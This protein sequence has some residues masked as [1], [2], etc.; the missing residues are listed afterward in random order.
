METSQSLYLQDVLTFANTLTIKFPMAAQMRNTFLSAAGYTVDPD[1]QTTWAY[2]MNL[3]GQYHASDT[4]MTVVSLD[5]LETIDFT[6]DNLLSHRATAAAYVFGSKYYNALVANFPTQEGLIRGIL[7]P[8]DIDTAIAADDYTILFYDSSHVET[9]EVYFIDELQTWVNSFIARY[10]MNFPSQVQLH[11]PAAFWAVLHAHLPGEII[12]IRNRY[13]RTQYT[14][15]YHI[16][17]YLGSHNYLNQY[18]DYCSLKQA[19]YLYRNIDYIEAHVGHSTTFVDLIAHIL[20]DR[21]I[22]LTA[23]VIQHDTSGIP[24]S[25]YSTGTVA[26]VPQNTLAES[27]SGISYITLE[28]AL[29]NES[30]IAKDNP[31]YLAT[32][33][34]AVPASVKNATTN[35]LPTKV[36]E[37]ILVDQSD[38]MPHKFADTL[39]TE[40]IF[41]AGLGKYTAN[42]TIQESGSEDTMS[43]T[44]KEALILWTYC[45][46][47]QFGYDMDNLAIPALT[48][49]FAQRIPAPTYSELRG[50]TDSKWVSETQ[51]QVAMTETTPVTT[52]ISTDAFYTIA[53]NIHDN[54]TA[55]RFLYTTTEDYMMRGQMEVL[56][57]RFYCNMKIPLSDGTTTFGAWLTE[58]NWSLLASTPTEFSTLAASIYNVATGSDLRTTI[59]VSDIHSAMIGIMTQLSSYSVQYIHQTEAAPGAILDNTAIRFGNTQAKGAGDFKVP[60]RAEVINAQGK[61]LM[62]PEEDPNNSIG[63]S[64]KQIATD[65]YF[66]PNNSIGFLRGTDINVTHRFTIAEVRFKGNLSTDLALDITETAL[67]GLWLFYAEARPIDEIV[68][69]TAL[70]GLWLYPPQ[71]ANLINLE[72][73]TRYLDGLNLV[74]VVGDPAL[75]LTETE[76]NGL[77]VTAIPTLQLWQVYPNDLLSGLSGVTEKAFDLDNLFPSEFFEGFITVSKKMH[78]LEDLISTDTLVGF[79]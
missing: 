46:M 16:W 9:Q 43:M 48:A 52:I 4:M 29:S 37:S 33:Q 21:R 73:T 34:T 26:K 14:H 74:K 35:T 2:Y 8:I 18:Q 15:S 47:R 77:I 54:I 66:A 72:V 78:L 62:S 69:V 60:I 45:V 63:F 17:S 30:G 36:L 40:W 65:Y 5:T 23:Y 10:Y 61:G 1:D 27:T 13:V 68:T 25:I 50:V 79:D 22:P 75:M 64:V 59:S 57:D 44:V 11:Y 28:T 51:I 7:N 39:L 70:S 3:A 58:K 38:S 31:T 76:L 55:H 41:L 71:G 53:A 12:N 42:I 67:N 24:E 19:L 20:T 6:Y 32:Q 56:C 49:F